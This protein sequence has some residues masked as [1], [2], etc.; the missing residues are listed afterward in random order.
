[1]RNTEPE[2]SDARRLASDAKEI[3]VVAAIIYSPNRQQILIAKRPDHL[4]QGGLWEFPGGKVDD[5]ESPEAALGREL[6]EELNIQVV[7]AEPF[8]Q[9]SHRYPDKAVF[10]DFWKVF[11][12]AGDP[13]GNEG[14]QVSWVAL[15]EL[16]EYPFPEANK[17]IL[18]LIR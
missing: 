18:P 12:F 17:P 11:E 7:E 9:L 8:H 16:D 5:G 2:V 3:H 4:H 6:R 1:M 14:Q 15:A 13:N 10:L